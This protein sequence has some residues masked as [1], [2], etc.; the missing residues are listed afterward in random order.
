MVWPAGPLEAELVSGLLVE[1]RD[2][3]GSGWPSADMFQSSVET[4]MHDRH[5]VFLLGCS[6][7]RVPSHRA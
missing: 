6:R 1:F 7:S 2:W 3:A 5:T 4:L